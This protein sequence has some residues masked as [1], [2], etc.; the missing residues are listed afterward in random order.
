MHIY[1]P[2]KPFDPPPEYERRYDPDQLPGPWFRESDLEAQEKLADAFFQTSPRHPESFKAREI[3]AKYYAMI[4]LIDY[5]V[6]RMLDALERTGQRGNTLVIFT[7]DH[8]EMLGDHGLMLKG[9]R[10]YEGLVR[11]PLILSLPGRMRQGV[12]SDA[13]VELIDLAPTVLELA[14]ACLPKHL[15]GRS[16][17]PV[18]TGENTGEHRPHVRCEYY[19]ALPKETETI[20]PRGTYATMIRDRRYKLVVYHGLDTGELFDLETDPHEFENLWDSPGHAHIRFRLLKENFD[21]LAFAVDV[22]PEPNPKD[23]ASE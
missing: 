22:G 5:N 6:G 11:V 3:K 23:D 9:C 15:Q 18:L 16:L 1:D 12:V 21:A 2:H 4:E 13:L 10:F 20:N 17:Q 8:G 19:R 14:G 7:S